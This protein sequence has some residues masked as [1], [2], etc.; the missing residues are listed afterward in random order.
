MRRASAGLALASACALFAAPAQA[1]GESFDGK[2]YLDWSAGGSVESCIT[3]EQIVVDVEAIVGRPIFAPRSQADRV[4]RVDVDGAPP[5]TF[6]GQILL[7][8]SSGISLGA[9]ELSAGSAE[10]KDVASALA[11][12]LSIMADLPRTSAETKTPPPTI[13]AAP[14]PTPLPTP[15]PPPRWHAAVGLGPMGSLDSNADLSLGGQGT[16]VVMPPRFLPFSVTV[17][18]APRSSS[19]PTGTSY[20][21]L[22]TTVGASLCAPPWS[23]ARVALLACAGP[24]LTVLAGWGAGFTQSRGG[25][26]STVGALLHTYAAYSIGH[27]FRVVLGLAATAT[28]QRVSLSF[29]EG[30]NGSQTFYRT[31][32]VSVFTSIGVA[33][34]LF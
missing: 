4:L 11:L 7:M 21:L 17:L 24:D 12:A 27:G 6:T 26:S 29:T 33:A 18:S 5:T 28:P 16:V 23:R 22:S 20:T 3:R 8:T 13:P 32:I 31:P 9:R 30:Q 2:V 34:D 14:A 15:T 10:C 19:T 1:D 25:L